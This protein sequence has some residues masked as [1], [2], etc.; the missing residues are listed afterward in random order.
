MEQFKDL[1]EKVRLAAQQIQHLKSVRMELDQQVA[2]LQAEKQELQQQV[3]RLEAGRGQKTAAT[4]ELAQLRAERAD[5]RQ[6]VER[7]VNEL[8]ELGLEKD[9]QKTPRAGNRAGKKAAP[10]KAVAASG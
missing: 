7:L 6:R 10:A 1:E 4:E 3:D 5:I 8:A 9:Q 2:G